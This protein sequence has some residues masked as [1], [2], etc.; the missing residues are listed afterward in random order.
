MH[1]VSYEY[2][3]TDAWSYGHRAE[4]LYAPAMQTT[5]E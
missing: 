1:A 5:L 2:L 4:K 3:K